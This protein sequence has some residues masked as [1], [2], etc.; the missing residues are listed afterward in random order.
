[1]IIE[2]TKRI[3]WVKSIFYPG[4]GICAVISLI[5]FLTGKDT[6]GFIMAIF[7]VVW[8]LV[9]L[10]IDF[11]Y[12]SFEI[13][14]DRLFLRYFSIVRFGSKNYSVIDFPMEML[15]DIRI[16]KS[17][18]GWANDLILV[19]KTK[20]GIAEYPPVSLAALDK[21]QQESILQQ[22]RTFLKR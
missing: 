1:M 6:G 17:V 11:Q 10:F 22:L 18:F 3:K 15:Y 4:A 5:F 9:F 14:Q 21:N 13:K 19:V 12:V 7:L 16:E 2:N 20:K 8:F